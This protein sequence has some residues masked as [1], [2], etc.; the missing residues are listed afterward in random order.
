MLIRDFGLLNIDETAIDYRDFWR[1]TK[2]IL[3]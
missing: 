3:R 2:F 1:K